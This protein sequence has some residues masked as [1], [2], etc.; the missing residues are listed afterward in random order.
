MSIQLQMFYGKGIVDI[1]NQVDEWINID[2]SLGL[3]IKWTEMS[4][5]HDPRTD[6]QQIIIAV[7][8]EMDI[9]KKDKEHG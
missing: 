4:I 6:Q 5:N 3:D 7:W 8:Y 2:E 9:N 1:Q